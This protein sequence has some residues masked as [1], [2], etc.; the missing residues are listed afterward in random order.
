[1]RKENIHNVKT[2]VEREQETKLL[3]C[4]SSQ[5]LYCSDDRTS[6]KAYFFLMTRPWKDYSS[7]FV[8]KLANI[9]TFYRNLFPFHIAYKS[10][11]LWNKKHKYICIWS[12]IQKYSVL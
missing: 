3:V 5:Y 8:H 9:E 1:M 2:A 10:P 7:H 6:T 4:T 11:T 12:A